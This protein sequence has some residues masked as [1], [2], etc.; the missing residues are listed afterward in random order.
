MHKKEKLKKIDFRD[1]YTSQDPEEKL[2]IRDAFLEAT[3]IRYITWYSK[4]QRACF[5][6]LEKAELSKICKTQFV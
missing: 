1:Y 3:G 6:K 5:S 2:R 4:V